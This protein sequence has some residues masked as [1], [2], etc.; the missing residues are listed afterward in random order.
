MAIDRDTLIVQY[1]EFANDDETYV[2]AWLAQVQRRLASSAFDT[3]AEYED[4]ALALGCHFMALEKLGRRG[5]QGA[6]VGH[7]KSVSNA[8]GT[9]QDESANYVGSPSGLVVKSLQKHT[10]AQTT[11]GRMFLDITSAQVSQTALL[12]S[13]EAS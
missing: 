2:T 1:R 7:S 6:V 4:A 9:G 3:A 11:Y 12:V 5:A 8:D 10:L 13:T